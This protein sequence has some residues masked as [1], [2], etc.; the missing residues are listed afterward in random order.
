MSVFTPWPGTPAYSQSL[1]RG[2][3][4]PGTFRD[5]AEYRFFDPHRLGIH[6]HEISQAI[7]ALL[8]ADCLTR[9]S[10]R[11]LDGFS[12]AMMSKKVIETIASMRSLFEKSLSFPKA[13]PEEAE[14]YSC[15]LQ[16]KIAKS[17]LRRLG[18]GVGNGG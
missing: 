13:S 1:E 15:C 5:W 2:F 7:D 4:P 9:D 6:S 10:G 18:I 12:D 16:T 17:L 14:S 3:V 8:F 11:L